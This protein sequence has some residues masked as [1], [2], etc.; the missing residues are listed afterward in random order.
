MVLHEGLFK[1]K[2]LDEY[3]PFH[4]SGR[5]IDHGACRGIMA[6]YF[7]HGCLRVERNFTGLGKIFLPDGYLGAEKKREYDQIFHV[8]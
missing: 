2:A 7:F 5:S 8:L 1:F 6:F 3:T 4:C